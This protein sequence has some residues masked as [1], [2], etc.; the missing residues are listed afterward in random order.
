VLTRGP[1]SVIDLNIVSFRMNSQYLRAG[2]H[3]G[4][5]GYTYEPATLPSG[6]RTYTTSTGRMEVLHDKNFSSGAV[7]HDASYMRIVEAYRLKRQIDQ[8]AFNALAIYESQYND[9]AWPT[10]S[11]LTPGLDFCHEYVWTARGRHAGGQARLYDDVRRGVLHHV[12]QHRGRQRQLQR[13]AGRRDSHRHRLQVHVHGH[14]QVLDQ[15]ELQHDGHVV[16]RHRRVLRRDRERHA[17]AVRL[18][19]RRTFRDAPQ[20]HVQPEQRERA[21]P[22]DRLG[23]AGLQHRAQRLV[24]CRL[25]TSNNLDDSQTY[26]QPQPSTPAR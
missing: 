2:V 14:E 19:Q 24:R 7:G 6:L 5:V 1:A 21:E 23:R 11:R 20:F 18:Q 12:R 26:A 15:V 22:R 3:D 9:Q 4:I 16:L 8:Q 17:D 10:D 25:P 13:Q